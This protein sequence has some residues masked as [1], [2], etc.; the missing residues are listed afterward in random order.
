M[1][2]IS[3]VTNP[4]TI[5]VATTSVRPAFRVS[6]SSAIEG[7]GRAD[8][9]HGPRRGHRRVGHAVRPKLDD[10][11]P[12]AQQPP[13]SL[14]QLETGMPARC[15]SSAARALQAPAKKFGRPPRGRREH[16]LKRDIRFDRHLV[17]HTPDDGFKD[18]PGD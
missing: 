7:Q 13:T 11:R 17:E 12:G 18:L 10:E 15:W 1:P 6:M 2:K 5:M 3:H 8:E 4:A 9:D 16:R 14:V